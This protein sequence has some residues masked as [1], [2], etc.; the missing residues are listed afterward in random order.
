MCSNL[1]SASNAPQ[2]VQVAIVDHLGLQSL[3]YHHLWSWA[4]DV[5]FQLGY[6]ELSLNL[7]LLLLMVTLNHCSLLM[8]TL[9]T[10]H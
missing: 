7:V 5:T 1:Q 8:V 6:Y 4:V 3:N 9:I 2:H 10:K